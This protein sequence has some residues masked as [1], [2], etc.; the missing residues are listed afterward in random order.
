MTWNSQKSTK[1]VTML[2][3]LFVA[4]LP[5]LAS[6]DF[7]FRPENFNHLTIEDGLPQN[8]VRCIEEDQY[9]FLWLCTSDGLV[10]YDGY[11]FELVTQGPDG[12][13]ISNTTLRT[14]VADGDYLWIGTDDGLNKFDLRSGEFEKI[15]I[16][17]NNP[18]NHLIIRSLIKVNDEIWIGTKEGVYVLSTSNGLTQ[19]ILQNHLINARDMVLNKREVIVANYGYGLLSVNVETKKI[20]RSVI[21]EGD[22]SNNILNIFNDG[23]DL[24]L[25]T[26]GNGLIILDLQFKIEKHIK[27]CSE[28]NENCLTS[29]YVYFTSKYNNK[30][31]IGTQKG[32]N[33]LEPKSHLIKKRM[34]LTSY[35]NNNYITDSIITAK[36]SKSYL[37][38]GLRPGGLVSYK[39]PVAGVTNY[40]LNNN[41]LSVGTDKGVYAV[42]IENK[43]VLLGTYRG[44]YKLNK[45]KNILEQVDTV[46]A[47][48]DEKDMRIS[49]LCNLQ[50]NNYIFGTMGGLFFYNSNKKKLK[51]LKYQVNYNRQITAMSCGRERIIIAV[52]DGKI[53]QFNSTNKTFK[54][55]IVN[56]IYTPVHSIYDG[57][58]SIY[59]ATQSGLKK[60][61]FFE[62]NLIES[63]TILPKTF[64][65]KIVPGR[66]HF[67]I[68]TRGNGFYSL[69]KKTNNLTK[70]ALPYYIIGNT[71]YDIS[72]IDA[73]IWLSTN[74]GLIQIE[75][76][77]MEYNHYV[78]S[79]GINDKEYNINALYYEQKN[80]VLFAGGVTGLTSI[81][82]DKF[83][84]NINETENIVSKV[85]I[86]D[87]KGYSIRTYYNL[88]SS[89][90]IDEGETLLLKLGSKDSAIR[91][92]SDFNYTIE[93]FLG[94]LT[95]QL[96][97]NE[98]QIILVDLPGQDF[99]LKIG[100]S[101]DYSLAVDMKPYPWKRWWSFFVYLTFIII[102]VKL[103]I[104]KYKVI[105]ESQNREKL[106]RKELVLKRR[107]LASLSHELRT[108]LN[109][110]IGITQSSNEQCESIN[111]IK[112]SAH[113]LRSLIDNVLDSIS[114]EVRKTIN[115]RDEEFRVSQLINDIINILYV[116]IKQS[117][118][119]VNTNISP[120][121][122]EIIISDR[123]KIQ[124]VILNLVKNALK[125][126]QTATIIEITVSLENDQLIV[127]VSD[128]GVGI[129]YQEQQ[130]IF[131]EFYKVN[132]N[133]SGFG[134]G[135]YISK[136]ISKELGGDLMLDS[137]PEKGCEFIFRTPIKKAIKK[138]TPKE[139][140][141]KTTANVVKKLLILEDDPLNVYAMQAQLKILDFHKF[142]IVESYEAYMGIN[143]NNYGNI[144]LD[145][146]FE[147]EIY[148]GVN[149][150]EELRNNNYGGKIYILSAE[151]DEMIKSQAM[152]FVDEYFVKPIRLS[153]LEKILFH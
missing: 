50:G 16:L 8:N 63:K 30:I 67:Y 123:L 90:Q 58:Q 106:S 11:E 125:H 48:L 53:L 15:E 98:N 78:Q 6:N 42:A 152:E 91:F 117:K 110:I 143:K 115:I 60:F 109:A 132:V 140:A 12:S 23:D 5:S 102:A 10:R 59:L 135:L 136:L 104:K 71:I 86:V 137:A 146:N 107:Q 150:A 37:W 118:I 56:D 94:T 73:N 25:S 127:L 126:S 44:L 13:R 39:K 144:I 99:Q 101:N 149:L 88:P 129:N 3:L 111:Y 108:P 100:G 57:G 14:I 95:N 116:Y 85:S 151:S 119:T 66:D 1:L 52:A 33:I 19:K 43:D 64:V 9:G 147:H 26:Y 32:L 79:H 113:L 82:L 18:T 54:T 114:I 120:S 36:F 61:E 103:I 134:L 124:Q 21:L 96:E 31:W 112:S 55:L 142:T 139:I 89:V 28:A 128:N 7:E 75:L 83:L 45:I 68:G 24:Y 41:K 2:I 81:R 93:K 131:E 70:I 97:S 87:N 35:I 65:T 4:R 148:N 74:N 46:N 17:Q 133:K 72:L 47:Q 40:K 80:N 153:E 92:Q 105:Q 38:L 130:E 22:S 20:N 121:V 62:E 29:N 122:P 138:F 34:L 84:S 49:S 69:E 76:E 141:S 145:L 77:S 27:I 51:K